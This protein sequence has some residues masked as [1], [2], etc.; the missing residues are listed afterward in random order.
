MAFRGRGGR[1]YRGGGMRYFKQEPFELFPDIELPERRNVT[2]EEREILMWD[3]KLQ[4]YWKTSPYNL[5]EEKSED[6]D[7]ERYSD[8]AKKRQRLSRQPL[9]SYMNLEPGYFP[10][11][12][13]PGVKSSGGQK[14]K[15]KQ[16][17]DLQLDALFEKFEKKDQELKSGK[18][19]EDEEKDEEKDEDEESGDFSDDGDYE[20]NE[21]FDDDEDDFNMSDGGDDQ[22]DTYE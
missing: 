2:E 6:T 18:E 3:L 1:W 13:L 9:S 8:R 16:K 5:D 10:R 11:D 22:G 15:L 21:V 4:N 7:I 14:I 17:T 19:S 12:L 20:Q